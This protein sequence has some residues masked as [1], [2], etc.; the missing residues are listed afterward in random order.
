MSSRKE[1]D[2]ALRAK[3]FHLLTDGE[4]KTTLS[5]IPEDDQQ[6]EQI[7]RELRD[8]ETSA[9]DELEQKLV[10]SGFAP[11]PVNEQQCFECMY[12]MVHRKYCELPELM[13]PVEAEWWCRLWRI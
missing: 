4:L 1:E 7:L 12:Y 8:V 3:I 2:D 11:K 5:P 10:I 13:V 6:F 9:P